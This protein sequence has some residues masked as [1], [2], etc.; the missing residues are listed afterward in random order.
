MLRSLWQYILMLVL[1]TVVTHG[2]CRETEMRDNIVSKHGPSRTNKNYRSVWLSQFWRSML[3]LIEDKGFSLKE[4]V[5]QVFT[6]Q[7]PPRCQRLVWP[8][9]IRLILEGFQPAGQQKSQL[10][11]DNH[12]HHHHHSNHSNHHHLII[13]MIVIIMMCC[14]DRIGWII[15]VSPS[16]DVG[17]ASG[18]H[19]Q[20]TH[21]AYEDDNEN[22]DNEDDDGILD[23][24]IAPHC[25]LGFTW[26]TKRAQN[27]QKRI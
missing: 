25:F 14:W 12:H 10:T 1:I 22:D 9:I 6:A 23:A 5:L 3:S 2:R 13:I 26:V 18:P 15:A 20:M 11:V 8:A 19:L 17:H 16:L 7:I 4:A 24:D 21:S 27:G